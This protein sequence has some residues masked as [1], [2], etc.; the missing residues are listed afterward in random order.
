M[1]DGLLEPTAT[2]LGEACAELDDLESGLNALFAVEVVTE[3]MDAVDLDALAAGA[4]PEEAVD[5]DRLRRVLGG[6][7]GRLLGRQ[8]AG[9]AV[10]GGLGG[11]IGREIAGR[12][13][14]AVARSVLEEFDPEAFL[15]ELAP[16]EAEWATADEVV[17]IEVE[18]VDE[19]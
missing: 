1:S 6:P 10:G 17:T 13:G 8:L 11:V 19:E 3:T 5:H 14:A 7:S 2:D 12:A 18:A 16:P 4:P 15:E 9:Y